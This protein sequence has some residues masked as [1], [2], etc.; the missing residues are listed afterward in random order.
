MSIT[1]DYSHTQ[2]D[3]YP[4]RYKYTVTM[5]RGEELAFTQDGEIFCQKAEM[6]QLVIQEWNILS[7]IHRAYMDGDVVWKYTLKGQE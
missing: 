7:Q 1:L 2:S 5:Y 3:A 4:I 6:A